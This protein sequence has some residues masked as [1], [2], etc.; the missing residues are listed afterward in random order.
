MYFPTTLSQGLPHPASISIALLQ[1]SL[2][3]SDLIPAQ[4]P[5]F[6]RARLPRNLM[7]TCTH[8]LPPTPPIASAAV[9]PPSHPS[10]PVAA[11]REEFHISP[12]LFSLSSHWAAAIHPDPQFQPVPSPPQAGRS[13]PSPGS[14]GHCTRSPRPHGC[15]AAPHLRQLPPTAMPAQQQPPSQSR[16][17]SREKLSFANL[18]RKASPP[19]GGRPPRPPGP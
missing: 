4:T 12:T 1:V 10:Q 7:A 3:S 14:G 11:G 17:G 8:T 9:F 13:P 15:G 18:S 6:F 5:M 19:P 16:A 2:T